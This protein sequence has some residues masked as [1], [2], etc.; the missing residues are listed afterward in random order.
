MLSI[1]YKNNPNSPGHKNIF[2]SVPQLN[3]YK[4]ADSYY[5]VLDNQYRP[6]VE[7]LAKGIEGLCLL[8]K[9]WITWITT[10][11]K[12]ESLFLPFDFS[13]EYLGGLCLTITQEEMIILTI[14]FTTEATGW[15]VSPTSSQKIENIPFIITSEELICTPK[16]LIDSINISIDEIRK[17]I[18]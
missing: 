2:V 12:G 16:E 13:D 17:I 11:K 8:L 3:I 7:S 15:S 10:V 5:F 6:N 4:S 9:N 1:S 18:E 14:G